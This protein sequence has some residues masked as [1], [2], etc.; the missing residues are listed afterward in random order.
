MNLM[1]P[2]VLFICM[3]NGIFSP[4]L[5]VVVNNFPLWTV[6]LI[7]PDP[8]WLLFASNLFLSTLTLV[9][10][11]VP[12]ALYER[13]FKVQETND[14]SYLIWVAGAVLLTLPAFPNFEQLF[15]TPQS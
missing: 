9:V 5:L 14:I 3:V 11:G 4:F 6:G 12:A 8:N 10:S 7:P 1:L 13:F 15:F 2:L